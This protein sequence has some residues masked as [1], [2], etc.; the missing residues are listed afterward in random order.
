M[1]PLVNGAYRLPY[2]GL[3]AMSIQYSTKLSVRS[4]NLTRVVLLIVVPAYV[5][6]DNVAGA[7]ERYCKGVFDIRSDWFHTARW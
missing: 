6:V 1:N 7:S 3:F 4:R 5:E 2:R